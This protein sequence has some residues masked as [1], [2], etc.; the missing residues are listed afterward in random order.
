MWKL[1]LRPLEG[2]PANLMLEEL[3]R[4]AKLKTPKL[5]VLNTVEVNAFAY[6]SP[7]G[8]RVVLTR[9]L[10]EAFERGYIN[11][12]ELKGIIAHELGHH[13]NGDCLRQSLVFSLVS[14]FDF[15]SNA[16]LISGMTNI[17]WSASPWIDDETRTQYYLAGIILLIIGTLIKIPVIVTAIIA[18]H[19]SRKLEFA[20]D[21]FAA[22]L[23]SPK[24]VANALQKIEALNAQL[25]LKNLV[26]LPFPDRWTLRPKNVSPI[27]RLFESHPPIEKRVKAL[28]S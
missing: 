5:L 11:E 7:F 14:I 10:I 23:T 17:G 15:I 28:L 13:K 20:A 25:T 22:K 8:K 19:H 4:A 24:I 27:E 6:L 9:G 2:H 3:S 16:F 1:K 18:F 21:A 12:D 26:A